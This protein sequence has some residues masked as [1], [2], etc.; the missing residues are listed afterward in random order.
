VNPKTVEVY[1]IL[2]RLRPDTRACAC[3]ILT[4]LGFVNYD[5]ALDQWAADEY[6]A[7]SPSMR[8]QMQH[9]RPLVQ[10]VVVIVAKQ[11]G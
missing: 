6:G 10:V 9:R 1:A 11:L 7:E 4:G 3:R 2:G 5:D 8:E